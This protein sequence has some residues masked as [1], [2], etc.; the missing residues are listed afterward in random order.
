MNKEDELFLAKKTAEE[1]G[2]TVIMPGQRQGG[3]PATQAPAAPA[4]PRRAPSIADQLEQLAQAARTAEARA[5]A[6]HPHHKH[7]VKFRKAL[8][9]H[10]LH[11]QLRHQPLLL[12]LLHQRTLNRSQQRTQIHTFRPLLV[13]H[14]S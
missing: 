11:P 1:A 9:Q 2:Y 5:S 6:P 3:A 14:R 12:S 10:Q 13:S 8:H 7:R 4:A